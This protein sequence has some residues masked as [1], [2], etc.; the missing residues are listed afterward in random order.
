MALHIKVTLGTEI[1]IIVTELGYY[2]NYFNNKDK[3][4]Y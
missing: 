2:C 1:V 3:G 4:W